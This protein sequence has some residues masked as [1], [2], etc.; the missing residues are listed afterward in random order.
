MNFSKHEESIK[1]VFDNAPFKPDAA[2]ILGSGLGGFS[3][4]VEI[5][6]T[7]R[8][9]DIPGYPPSTV[10]GHGGKIHFARLKEKRLLLFDGRI[11]FY[12][13]YPLEKCLFPVMFTHKLGAKQLLITN[14][15]GGVSGDLTPGD[16]MLFNSFSTLNL[17]KEISEALGSFLLKEVNAI[18]N[19]PDEELHGIIRQAAEEENIPIKEGSYFFSKG[20]TYETPAEVRMAAKL[21]FDA[22]GM[23]TVHEIITALK[24]GIRVASISCITNYAAGIS[25]Q[26]LSH[27]EVTET[28]NRIKDEFERLIKK[29]F[30]LLPR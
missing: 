20:P 24:L 21:G 12:E 28:A 5:V 6:K 25:A 23:S 13:G 19:F 9:M 22:V 7:I 2:L 3:G 26:K 16:L 11:H 14:A 1:F 17:K 18:R 27:S 30:E 8:T 29:I 4:S 10:E 15:A